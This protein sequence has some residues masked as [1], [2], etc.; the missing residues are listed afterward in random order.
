MTPTTNAES[1]VRRVETPRSISITKMP[2]S[3]PIKIA[4]ARERSSGESRNESKPPG[5]PTVFRVVPSRETMATERAWLP[6][7]EKAIVPACEI[8]NSDNEAPRVATFSAIARGAPES[9]WRFAS[10][11]WANR[12]LPRTNSGCGISATATRRNSW[13]WRCSSR[14]DRQVIRDNRNV[15]PR[16]CSAIL[17]AAFSSV[18]LWAAD[19]VPLQISS[20]TAPAGGWAQI[21]IFAVKPMAIASSHIVVSLDPAVFGS[22]PFAGLF[23]VNGD[24]SGVATPSD[25]QIDVQFSS[26]T[27]GIGQLAGLPVLVISAPV[28]ASA[29]GRTVQVKA[30]SPDSSVSIAPGSVTVSGT[31]SVSKI[32]TGMGVLPAGTVVPV[33][34]TG[35]TASTKVTIDGVAIASTKFVSATET[36]VTLGGATEL[37]GKLARVTDNGVEFDYFCFQPNAAVNNPPSTYPGLENVQPLFP[38]LAGTGF[39][40]GGSYVGGLVAAQNPNPG[41]A[42]VSFASTQNC[43]A[44]PFQTTLAPTVSIPPGDWAFFAQT[45]DSSSQLKSDLPVRVVSMSYCLSARQPVCTG[46][47]PFPADINT[48]LGLTPTAL[49]A[50][51]LTF[52]WQKGSSVLP[53]PRTVTVADTSSIA[54]TTAQIVSGSPWLSVATKPSGSQVTTLTVSVNPTQLAVGAYQGSIQVADTLGLASTPPATLPVTL[55]VTDAPVPSIAADSPSL[56]FTAPAFNADPYTQTISV[57]SATPVPFS[58]SLPPHT[59]VKVS[60][61]SGT[62]PATLNVT[63]DPAVTSQIYYQQRSTP[64]SI[65]INGP[66]NTLTVGA[67]FNVTGV[68]TFQMYLFNAGYGPNGLIF[69]AQRGSAPQTQTINVDPTGTISALG[70]KPWLS[71]ITPTSGLGANQTV[72]VTAN[73]AGLASGTYHGSVTISEPGIASQTVPVTL[74]VWST[75]PTPTIS[76]SSFTFVDQVGGSGQ[77]SQKAQVDSGGVPLPLNILTGA[78]WLYVTDYYEAPTPTSIQVGVIARPMPPGEYDGSFTLQNP[79]GSVY[80]PV[81]LLIE[82]APLAPPVISQ[83][84]NAA[85]GIAGSVSPGEILT[86]RGYGVGASRT[87]GLTLD[88]SGNVTT[89]LNGLKVTFDG[90][91][92]PLIYTSASQT[93]LI[94]PY[95]VAGKASTVMQVTYAATAGNLQTAAWTLPVAPSAPA[96]FTLDATGTGQGA[97]LNQ[98]GGVNGAANAA[99]RGSVISVFATGEGQTTPAGVT[100]SVSPASGSKPVLPVAVKIGGLDATVQHAGSAPGLVAGLLQVNAVVPASI[101][102]GPAVPLMVSVGGVPSQRDVTIAVR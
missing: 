68:Q 50:D 53:A 74:T 49:S 82:P 15:L 20:E 83:V 26:P 81:T 98:D 16:N 73:P 36:D 94:V 4:R 71:T 55:T 51:S 43:C 34:G 1:S 61:M 84:V 33:S 65:Q 57:T 35:F 19:P 80:V 59:W 11:G 18:G 77:P 97:V 27:G 12:V 101:A 89:N 90:K 37:V 67:T 66:A 76:Q 22:T 52:S 21:K 30:T 91:P 70:D 5:L 24:A 92:A 23:G 39:R 86:I 31:V 56:T 93:N 100:G 87:G 99:A 44:P 10:K 38:L 75:A 40:G 7:L 45:P 13:A 85:S 96:I 102:P 32:P 64:A 6:A 17:Y 29:A 41:A 8:E 69:S 79:G 62:T 88:A 25:S 54:A 63:W 14:R 58:V 95:E 72:Q 47:A 48:I 28:L 2:R 9:A 42:T 46:I 78:S 60:P 3:G